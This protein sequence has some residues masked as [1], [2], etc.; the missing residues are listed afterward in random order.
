MGTVFR[1]PQPVHWSMVGLRLELRQS[2]FRAGTLNC[3]ALWL[4]MGIND[5]NSRIYYITPPAI[6][7][8]SQCV[9]YLS[10]RLPTFKKHLKNKIILKALG[11]RHY[12]LIL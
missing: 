4:T 11:H 12:I 3:S 2:D 6:T 1:D 8:H 9:R 7:S 10:R 5:N